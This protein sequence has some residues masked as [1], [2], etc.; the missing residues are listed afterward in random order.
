MC[1]PVREFVEIEILFFEFCGETHPLLIA[2]HLALGGFA[3]DGTGSWWEL[4]WSD[5]WT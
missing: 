5:W 2:R 1:S 4:P 3:P